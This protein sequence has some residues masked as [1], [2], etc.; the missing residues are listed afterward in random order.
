MEPDD[1]LWLEDAL[2][3]YALA[4]TSELRDEIARTQ[5]WL[6]VRSA[7]RFTHRGEPFDDL[8]QV[9][10]I[11][12]LKAI[13]RFDSERAVPF[14]AF[15]TPTMIGELRRHFRD[16]TWSVYVPRRAK[17]L[18]S[19]V[20]ATAEQLAHE[21]HRSPTVAEVAERAEMSEDTVVEALEANEAYRGV[22]LDVIGSRAD[23][24]LDG[25]FDAVIDREALL[26]ALQLLQPRERKILYLRFFEELSQSQIAEQVG[27]SQVHVGRLIAASLQQLRTQLAGQA[28]TADV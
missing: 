11:G 1:D 5:D 2:N 27:T 17:D 6:A 9:A 14:G 7:H 23:R 3:R 21:L 8:L 22:S 28:W 10:R 16:R 25:V 24:S 4:P 15:A 13:E 18:R 19:A 26:D 20:N 12:L